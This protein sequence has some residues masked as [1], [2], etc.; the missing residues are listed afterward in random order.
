MDN[1]RRSRFLNHMRIMLLLH[2]AVLH[3]ET[4]DVPT[5]G[6]LLNP[7]QPIGRMVTGHK[8]YAAVTL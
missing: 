4:L 2:P 1:K 6:G 3:V 8:R 7:S 5:H